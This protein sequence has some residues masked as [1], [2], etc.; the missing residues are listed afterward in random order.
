MHFNVRI[1]LTHF[2]KVSEDL[3]IYISLF[4]NYPIVD[5]VS[6]LPILHLE[7]L[8]DPPTVLSLKTGRRVPAAFHSQRYL[9]NQRVLLPLESR[10]PIQAIHLLA[11]E[12][13]FESEMTKL[14]VECIGTPP[15]LE[16]TTRHDLTYSVRAQPESRFE[17]EYTLVKDTG[18]VHAYPT[19]RQLLGSSTRGWIMLRIGRERVTLVSVERRVSRQRTLTDRSSWNWLD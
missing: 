15:V 3:G 11:T 18:F 6:I 8:L 7:A 12:D 14:V 1:L 17:I 13:G 10:I 16:T 4:L 5:P 2:R 19:P 9:S